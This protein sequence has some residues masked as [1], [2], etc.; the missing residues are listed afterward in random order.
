MII[1]HSSIQL[2]DAVE[3]NDFARPVKLPEKAPLEETSAT[4]SGWGRLGQ[5]RPLS[6]TLQKLPVTVVGPV[7]CQYYIDHKS[8]FNLPKDDRIYPN[9]LCGFTFKNKGYGTCGVSP[10]TI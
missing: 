10:L 3:F 4:I 8:N 5:N 7:A 6:Q 1:S 2:K 9:E